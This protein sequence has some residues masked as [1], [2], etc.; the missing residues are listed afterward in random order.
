MKNLGFNCIEVFETKGVIYHI[1]NTYQIS[2]FAIEQE[3]KHRRIHIEINNLPKT[4]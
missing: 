1:R 2:K 4:R 3:Q